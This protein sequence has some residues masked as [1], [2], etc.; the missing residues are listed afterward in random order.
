MVLTSSSKVK[1]KE[2]DYFL[3]EGNLLFSKRG[4]FMDW[5]AIDKDYIK[6]LKDFDIYVPNIEYKDRMK[7]FLGILLKSD[8]MD[9]F[10]PLTSY[11]PKFTNMKNDIDFYKIV[12]SK[13]QKIYGAIDLNNMIPVT[14]ENYTKITFDNLQQFREFTS[15]RDKKMYWKLLCTEASYI[16]ENLIL[17]NAEK[18][19]RLKEQRPNNNI[20]KRCCDFKLLEEKCKEYIEK[21]NYFEESKDDFDIDITEE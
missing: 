13:T 6:Y 9:Y 4:E 7:C 11:K 20:S 16:D 8:D 5:Y 18:L 21:Q 17:E 10:A 19:Y 12:N 3:I 2:E 15:L 14:S 1:V